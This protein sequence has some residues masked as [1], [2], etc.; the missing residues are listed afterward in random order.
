MHIK[1]KII[2]IIA[3]IFASFNL[4]PVITSVSPLLELF[5]RLTYERSYC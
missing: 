2:P 1:R 3:I 4:R 5:V